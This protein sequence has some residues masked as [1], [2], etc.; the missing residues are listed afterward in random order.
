MRIS[1]SWRKPEDKYSELKEYASNPSSG[2]DGE[3]ILNTTSNTINVWYD[4]AWQVLHT[5]TVSTKYLLET[6]DSILL[7]AGDILLLES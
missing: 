1:M 4:S 3:M 6:G 5:L 2:E 7:E